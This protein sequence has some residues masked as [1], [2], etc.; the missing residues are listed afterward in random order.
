MCHMCNPEGYSPISDIDQRKRTDRSNRRVPRL[1]TLRISSDTRACTRV[2]AF[3]GD[4]HR[5]GRSGNLE[6]TSANMHTQREL[7]W[8]D[9]ATIA[10]PSTS[11]SAT[12]QTSR[13]SAVQRDR[14]RAPC[15]IYF[16]HARTGVTYLP[17][18]VHRGRRP[19]F[20]PENAN[21]FVYNHL[22]TR[23]KRNLK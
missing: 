20:T 12:R 3:R 13:C 22:R 21:S 23:K 16:Q 4:A 5:D 10:R 2:I 15:A 14:T 1:Q 17:H 6:R 11:A 19:L 9:R 7:G 8:R 18:R